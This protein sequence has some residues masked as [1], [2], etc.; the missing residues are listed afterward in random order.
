MT[1]VSRPTRRGRNLKSR[2]YRSSFGVPPGQCRDMEGC[3]DFHLAPAGG[4]RTMVSVLM[5]IGSDRTARLNM[6]PIFASEE[7]VRK[8]TRLRKL[9]RTLYSGPTGYKCL[10][11]GL[12]C[13]VQHLEYARYCKVL[14]GSESHNKILSGAFPACSARPNIPEARYAF[15]NPM[16]CTTDDRHLLL[17]IRYLVKKHL[18]TRNASKKARRTHTFILVSPSILKLCSAS[19]A[20]VALSSSAYSTNAISF[21]AGIR[22]TSSRLGYLAG[23]ASIRR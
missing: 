3:V 8:A 20:T 11:Q 16:I 14:S 9:L 2:G 21:L 1:F 19:L 6:K 17:G 15:L 7:R 18:S 4:K 23:I 10:A 5:S 12:L 13:P 22:R